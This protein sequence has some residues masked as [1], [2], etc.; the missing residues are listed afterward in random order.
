MLSVKI[1]FKSSGVKSGFVFKL[2][3]MILLS[4]STKKTP[5]LH[6]GSSILQLFSPF[7]F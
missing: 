1:S 5:D 4:A 3:S 2:C 7:N 6:D